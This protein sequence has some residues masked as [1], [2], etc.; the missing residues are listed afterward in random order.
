M[1]PTAAVLHEME[2]PLPYTNSQPIVIEE[3]EL[4]GP[5]EDEVLVE[6]KGAGLCHSDLSVINGSRPRPTPMVLGHEASGIVREV[7]A[8]VR[9]IQP[10]DH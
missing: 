8:G 9:G 1:K 6:V 10:D 7:G 4:E 5:G 3:L 2:R